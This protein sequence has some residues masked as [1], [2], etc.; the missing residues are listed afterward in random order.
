MQLLHFWLVSIR[1]CSF[2]LS[3]YPQLLPHLVYEVYQSGE[4]ARQIYA[5]DPSIFLQMQWWLVTCQ[6]PGSITADVRNWYKSVVSSGEDKEATQ[7]I[8]EHTLMTRQWTGSHCES[9]F[10]PLTHSQLCQ[11]ICDLA[12]RNQP[13]SSGPST[14]PACLLLTV[15]YN[16]AWLTL[17]I[18]TLSTCLISPLQIS[19]IYFKLKLPLGGH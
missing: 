19:V 16:P 15:F 8:Q 13:C 1:A 18:L 14:F 4:A 10:N 3:E 11:L 5:I 17:F 6:E 2:A 7:N 9:W 12:G